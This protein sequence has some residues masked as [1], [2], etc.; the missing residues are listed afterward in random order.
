MTALLGRF[1][2]VRTE[3]IA[4]QVDPYWTKGGALLAQEGSGKRKGKLEEKEAVYVFAALYFCA[5]NEGRTPS[6]R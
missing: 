3:G 1:W 2:C 4:G 6:P 5:I